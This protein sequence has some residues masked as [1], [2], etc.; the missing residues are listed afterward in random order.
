MKNVFRFQGHTDSNRI[1]DVSDDA[2]LSK[3]PTHGDVIS[4]DKNGKVESRF[5]DDRWSFSNYKSTHDLIFDWKHITEAN[6]DMVKKIM[7]AMLFYPPLFPGK[8]LSLRNRL[9]VLKIL[10]AVC[11]AHRIRVTEAWKFPN[12]AKTFVKAIPSSMHSVVVA[13]LTRLLTYEDVIGFKIVDENFL[14]NIAQHLVKHDTNQTPYIPPRIWSSV[15][16]KLNSMLDD[17]L[18]HEKEITE[19]HHSLLQMYQHNQRLGLSRDYI[20]P[21]KKTNE[22]LSTGRLTYQGGAAQ[23]FK[24]RN[25]S[26]LLE[27]YGDKGLNLKSFE[28]LMTRF[29]RACAIYIQSH[30]IQ[31]I[32]EVADLRKDCFTT[33]TDPKH[34]TIAMICGE[35]TKTQPDG[36]ARW[37]VPM[38]VKKAIDVAN[39]ISQLN[40]LVKPNGMSKDDLRNPYLCTKNSF[41]WSPHN[42]K[43]YG[44]IHVSNKSGIGISEL[45]TDELLITEEDYKLAR[46]A[47]P[48]LVNNDWFRVGGTWK[49]SSHQF[50]RT[51]VMNMFSQGV[52]AESVSYQTKHNS[53][54][55]TF[56]YARNWTGVRLNA[57]ASAEVRMARHTAIAS[58]M[59]D[60][61]N[62]H[63]D[64]FSKPVK[65]PLV[66]ENVVQTIKSNEFEKIVK[67]VKKGVLSMRPTLLGACM[68]RECEYGGLES[69]AHCAGTDGKGPCK[70]LVFDKR[71]RTKNKN[72]LKRHKEAIK[73]C[74]PGTP[75]H[76]KL[77]HEIKALEVFLD[78]TS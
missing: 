22:N 15:I 38:H 43:P 27:R 76:T 20:S 48:S 67:D 36:D 47:E 28:G 70:D 65:T 53:I 58:T 40:L 7:S 35:T 71:R 64:N 11:D 41:P 54:S 4:R 19:V 59:C 34:G 26:N 1:K 69:A 77:T 3:Y 32:S 18:Q 29:H 5:D 46:H 56:Y 17:F 51:L 10:A 42:K 55:Q 2:E 63:D 57:E 66:S 16:S 74:S 44:A 33:W 37:I 68:A 45:L 12:L 62:N 23:F 6:K 61:V 49:L 73:D 75:P 9:S 78:G 14:D 21:F 30:S 72:L 39:K 60:V 8:I 50:R 13:D 52:S 31:R 25:L 24:D